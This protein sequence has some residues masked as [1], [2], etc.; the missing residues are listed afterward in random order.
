MKV[1]V[2]GLGSMGKRRIRL[3]QKFSEIEKIVGI[4]K[5]T[6]RRDEVNKIY[7]C[8][9]YE[10]M[11]QAVENEADLSA[12]FICTSPLSHTKLINDALK[13]ELNVFSEINLIS[14]GYKE[15]IELA[16]KV[17]KVLFLSSTFYYREEIKYLKEKIKDKSNLNYIYHIGQYLPDW[18]PWE[19]YLDFFVADKRTNG[20]REI[21]A[22]EFP[23]LVG[24]FG[25]VKKYNVISNNISKLKIDYKDN[26][27]IQLE[28]ENGNK[29]TLV[30]DIV[31]QKAV[32]NLEVYGENIY[33][34]WNGTPETLQEF[35]EKTHKIKNVELREEAENI[36]GYS[37]FIVENA[38]QSEIQEFIDVVNGDKVTEYGFEEDF[39]ILKLIDCIEGA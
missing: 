20:C 35:D 2:I 5:R 28:H 1:L 39:E 24:A 18:H 11:E 3:L 38:Y 22:I 25:T 13:L 6:D 8:E 33:F 7:G 27:M 4:D 9:T 16:K 23:W 12:A 29:G 36:K 26:Y 30:V 31:S 10:S 19:D 32:R 34:S 21:M 15:N 17:N 37:S 14:D